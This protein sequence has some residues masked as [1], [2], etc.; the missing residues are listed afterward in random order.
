MPRV[1][2]VCSR[3]DRREIDGMIVDGLGN[4]R[5]AATHGVTEQALRRHGAHHLSARLRRAAD[6]EDQLNARSLVSRYAELANTAEAVRIAAFADGDTRGTVLAIN[7]ERQI[8]DVLI[9]R[10]KLSD[11]SII[12]A[13]QE[14]RALA[15]ALNEVIGNRP[16]SADELAAALRARSLPRP[17]D[18]GHDQAAQSQPAGARRQHRF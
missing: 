15:G 13:D 11:A 2:T 5:I 18:D 1:C 17:G 8:L 14:M 6:L 7:A 3:T 16:D 10:F 9:D 12:S 4:Q